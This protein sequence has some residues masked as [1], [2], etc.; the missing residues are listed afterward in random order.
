MGHHKDH[1][2]AN[3]PHFQA[4][5]DYQGGHWIQCARGHKGFKSAWERNQYYKTICCHCGG[6]CELIDIEKRRG[7]KS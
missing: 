4:R 6:G 7:P 2:T 3:C 1:L 5:N